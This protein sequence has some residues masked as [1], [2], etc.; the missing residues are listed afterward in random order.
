MGDR[1][2][3]LHAANFLRFLST[4]VGINGNFCILIEMLALELAAVRDDTRIFAVMIPRPVR[5]SVYGAI[6][7]D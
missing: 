6:L 3:R 1:L 4:F 7:V 5:R 2:R